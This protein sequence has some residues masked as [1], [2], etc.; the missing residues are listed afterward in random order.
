MARVR[1]AKNPTCAEFIEVLQQ[2]QH[3]IEEL[4]DF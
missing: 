1:S 4:L 2:L 3:N